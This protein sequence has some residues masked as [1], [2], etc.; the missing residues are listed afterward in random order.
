[1]QCIYESVPKDE[2]RVDLRI[3]LAL[4]A[5][6]P[7]DV[8]LARFPERTLGCAPALADFGYIVVENDVVIVDPADYAIVQVI[9]E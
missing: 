6:V 7:R 3:R 9:S 8:N 2:A 4:G 5:E 1:M